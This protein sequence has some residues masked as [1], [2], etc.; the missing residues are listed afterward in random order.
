MEFR[1]HWA[2]KKWNMDLHLAGRKRQ[3]QISEL[4]EWRE[5]AYHSSKIYKERTKRC[6][7]TRES[8]IKSSTQEIRF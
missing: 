1:A 8:N 6:G 4:E 2:I 7:M 5:K 3:M